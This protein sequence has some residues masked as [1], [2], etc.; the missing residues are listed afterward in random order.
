MNAKNSDKRKILIVG[1]SHSV[2][3]FHFLYDAYLDQNPGK[4]LVS[5]VVYYS[6]CA[7]SRHL[8]FYHNGEKVYRYYKN[9]NGAYSVTREL[10]LQTILSDQAWDTVFLQAAK[11][12]LDDTLNRAGRREL[13]EVVNQYVKNPH[14]FMWHTSWPSPNDETFFSPD[15]VRQPP[16]GYKDRL[17]Q[18]YGFD[19]ITQF[20]VLTD[21]AKAHILTDP[22]YSKAVCTGSAIMN[23]HVTQGIPQLEIWRDYT[24]LNDFG[25]LIAAYAMVVQLTEKKV[26]KVGIDTV[27]A[28]FRHQ[29]YRHLGDL[30]VTEEMKEIIK[31]AANHS[32]DAPWLVPQGKK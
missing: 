12:D 5:G 25:Q 21:K 6:G 4:E 24:H 8:Q 29:M 15:Y 27:P 2:D 10:D 17:I 30:T 31:I 28:A 19:P 32:L 7:I 22:V 26:E 13:E 14:Q 18:L 11:A 9:D 20:T 23:A 16:Q 1:N 3:A